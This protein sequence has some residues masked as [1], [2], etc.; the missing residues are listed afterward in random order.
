MTATTLPFEATLDIEHIVAGGDGLARHESLVVF[1]PRTLAGERVRANVTV[2]GR[3]ARGRLLSIERA[4]A[5]RVTPE[6]PHYDGDGCG[7]C[8]LQHAL[9]EEQL[10]A[11]AAI[12]V[13]AF[14]RIARL[15]IATPDVRAAGSP[16]RYR[17]KLTLALRK[18]G[19]GWYAGLRRQGAPNDVFPLRDCLITAEPVV[20]VW[21]DVLAA[22]AHLPGASTLR[23]GVRV[24]RGGG[25]SFVLE[26]SDVWP[27]AEAF[28][29]AVPALRSLWWTPLHGKR[30]RLAT[31]EAA[32]GASEPDASFAQVNAAT[33]AAML[34]HVLAR[35]RAH[36]P[37]H[38][39]DAYA[40]TGDASAVLDAE[41]VRVTAIEVD[42]DAGEWTANRLS[43]RSS[44][45]MD[46]VENALAG[47]LPADVVILN[48]PRT[49]V[50]AR[51]CDAIVHASPAPRAVVY[52][53]CDPA[54]LA[55]DVSRLPGWRIASLT[56]FD[57]FPQT[58][59]VETVCELVPV[60]PEAA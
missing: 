32:A 38:V 13:A 8:Q 23:G 35:V 21:R 58:A 39:I 18:N 17:R 42:R 1:V 6:C 55:R 40:G 41:G 52:V 34:P 49:G 37:Q 14:R 51:V 25:A 60:A 20:Q 53:S 9:Y 47:V 48:P 50:D 59:H 3:L 10:R 2:K 26:G 36:S 46:R 43:S 11:K 28:F 19:D 24:E 45:V 30:R 5:A 4:S 15:D 56:C 31:R 27:G 54:T 7:G 16:W 44:V 22:A 12:V 29:A 33:G 57:M